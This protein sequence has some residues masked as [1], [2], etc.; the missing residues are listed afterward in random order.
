MAITI[1]SPT[2]SHSNPVRTQYK[3]KKSL[4]LCEALNVNAVITYNRKN[5][6]ELFMG[7]SQIQSVYEKAK[8]TLS[9]ELVPSV[10]S[11]KLVSAIEWYKL[12][13]SENGKKNHLYHSSNPVKLW[14]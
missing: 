1:T 5:Y 11:G 6:E 8:V 14:P 2:Y 9:A 4:S 3:Y 12:W 7:E 10:Y 13:Q